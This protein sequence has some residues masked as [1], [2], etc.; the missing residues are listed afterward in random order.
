MVTRRGMTRSAI[1]EASVDLFGSRGFSAVSL[2][3]IA[4]VV[5]VAKQTVR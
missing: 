5:G 4:G 3:E 2:D 1:L